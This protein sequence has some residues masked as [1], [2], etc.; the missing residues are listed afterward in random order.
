MH[1]KII[2]WEE[3]SEVPAPIDIA[4]NVVTVNEV[5]NGIALN[6]RDD[7]H[8]MIRIFL[9]PKQFDLSNLSL[10]LYTID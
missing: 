1:I 5:G 8:S 3:N 2:L 10:F 6:L 7:E 4:I 9:E